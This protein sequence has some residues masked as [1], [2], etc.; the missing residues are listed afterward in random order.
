MSKIEGCALR[1]VGEL[2]F[3]LEKGACQA[4]LDDQV[5]LC[6]SGHESSDDYRHG[7]PNRRSNGRSV[8][9]KFKRKSVQITP[10]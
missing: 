3:V 10:E 4:R 5:M 1:N 2:P 9:N 8:A 6:F 7:Y